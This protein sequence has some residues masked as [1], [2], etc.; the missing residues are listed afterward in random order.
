[1]KVTE[2][3]RISEIL[4]LNPDVEKVLLN[5]GMNCSGCPASHNETLK[6]AAEGHNVSLQE[7]LEDL[8]DFLR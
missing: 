5:H 7:I 6:E 8:N 1:M 3:M 2:S 4:D